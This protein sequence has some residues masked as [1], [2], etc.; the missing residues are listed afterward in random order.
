MLAAVLGRVWGAW[1]ENIP[2]QLREDGGLARGGCG[3]TGEMALGPRYGHL[4]SDRSNSLLD[5]PWG[6]KGTHAS[7]ECFQNVG[8]GHQIKRIAFY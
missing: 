1:L 6:V 8:L 7:Q 5:H 2:I 4:R 3:T